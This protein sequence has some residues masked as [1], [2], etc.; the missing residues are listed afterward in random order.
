MLL[1]A[2]DGAAISTG[3]GGDEADSLVQAMDEM[4]A[5]DADFGE[6]DG[7]L[8]DFGAAVGNKVSHHAE[9]HLSRAPVGA[10]ACIAFD[11]HILHVPM[12]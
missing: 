5:G 12:W 10:N 6:G 11:A 7:D 2:D 3:N 8:M 1:D 9:P 4:N